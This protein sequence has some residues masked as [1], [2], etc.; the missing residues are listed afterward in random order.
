MAM[1]ER[2]LAA[3]YNREAYNVVDHYTYVICGD[4][5]LME[6]VSAEASSLAAHLGLGR[7]VVLYDSN[8]ISLDGDLDRSFSES[9]KG[10]Y[11]AYGWQYIRVE[12][13]M[14]V[15]AIAKALEEAKSDEKPSDI[16]RSTYNHRFRF[17]K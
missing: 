9:V 3:K 11:E 17:S 14:D 6:G 2:H 4:G 5:D 12:D 15:A 16:N 1:A 8:D 13:G 7:L 10:R